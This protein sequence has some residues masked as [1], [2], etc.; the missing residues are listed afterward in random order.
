MLL[1][2][3]LSLMKV[4][5]DFGSFCFPAHTP[6]GA[7]VWFSSCSPHMALTHRKRLASCSP[8]CGLQMA[9]A[10]VLEKILHAG[11]WKLFCT[12]VQDALVNRS[13][14]LVFAM[15]YYLKSVGILGVCHCAPTPSVLPSST[16]QSVAVVQLRS[17]ISLGKKKKSSRRLQPDHKSFVSV[18]QQQECQTETL[19]EFSNGITTF[20]LQGKQ[21]IVK[22]GKFQQGAQD[23][24]L[25]QWIYDFRILLTV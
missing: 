16:H 13:Q 20:L 8:P 15:P 24:C 22:E 10:P 4:G 1:Q 23:L 5:R 17:Q 19:R 9:P 21:A 18:V 2:I 11:L 12:W 7:G 25:K 6:E 14:L 3:T